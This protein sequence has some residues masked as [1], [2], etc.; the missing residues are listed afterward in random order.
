MSRLKGTRRGLSYLLT[1]EKEDPGWGPWGVKGVCGES[2]G[3]SSDVDGLTRWGFPSSFFR[4]RST[5]G[6][7]SGRSLPL[8]TKVVSDVGT[9]RLP[10][11]RRTPHSPPTPMFRGLSHVQGRVVEG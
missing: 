7:K 11:G 3:P 1:V 2:L 6:R 9:R 10:R 4:P 8:T 5:G